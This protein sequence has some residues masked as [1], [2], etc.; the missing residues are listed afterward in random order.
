[1]L[2]IQRILHPSDFSD[3]ANEAF[4]YALDLALRTGAELQ[5][6]HVVEG[7]EV[8]TDET[9]LTAREEEAL[10][11]RLRE[12]VNAHISAYPPEERNR[13]VL[14]YDLAEGRNPA[15]AIVEHAKRHKVDL[16]VLG[17]HG[18]RGLRHL[19]LGSDAEEVMRRAACPVMIVHQKDGRNPVTI[20]HVVAPI[21]F[22][23]YAKEALLQAKHLA[24]LHDAQLSLV[25]VGEEHLV[26]FFSDTGI[27]TFSL[28]RM[29]PDIIAKGAEALEQLDRKVGGPEVATRYEVRT[30]QPADEIIDYVQEHEVG[31]IVMATRGLSRV[32]QSLIGSVTERVA[33]MAPCPVWTV[34]PDVEAND[35]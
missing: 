30:G 1:M 18:R 21:D 3:L 8:Y 9:H 14:T 33:R 7:S 13:L 16:I 15:P 27:P 17:T 10:L 29:D 23:D 31:L 25:F 11:V 28:L 26:P 5:V 34:Q 19:F 20:D 6:L 12:S 35:E 32:E 2:S 4:T 24:A 22:S